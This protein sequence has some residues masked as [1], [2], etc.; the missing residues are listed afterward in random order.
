MSILKT[1]PPQNHVFPTSIF[2]PKT[3]PAH[4]GP[5]F[6]IPY[7]VLLV[8][9]PKMDLWAKNEKDARRKTMQKTGL[10]IENGAIWCK[11]WLKTI[12]GQAKP[13]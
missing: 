1:I 5:N 9:G 3:S 2:G 7:Q 4:P 10:G 12:L 11:L 13:N 6:Q 8:W